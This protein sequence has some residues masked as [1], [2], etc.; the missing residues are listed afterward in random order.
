MFSS[1]RQGRC[2]GS[3]LASFT[4]GPQAT[5]THWGDVVPNKSCPQG[6]ADGRGDGAPEPRPHNTLLP[7]QAGFPKPCLTPTQARMEVREHLRKSTVNGSR[8]PI[9]PWLCR[10]LGRLRESN[11]HPWQDQAFTQDARGADCPPRFEK[12][13]AQVTSSARL[14]GGAV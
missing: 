7:L 6:C 12:T 13:G 9:R 14:Q 4:H 11:T 5:A 3:S 10:G 2:Q 8:N 1:G